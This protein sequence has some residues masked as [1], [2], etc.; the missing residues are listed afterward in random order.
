MLEFFS[1]MQFLEFLKWFLKCFWNLHF[2]Y[3]EVWDVNLEFWS[4]VEEL[5]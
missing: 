3:F 1:I 4:F 2:E 5:V